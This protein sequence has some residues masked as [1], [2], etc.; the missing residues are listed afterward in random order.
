MGG[1]RVDESMRMANGMKC[2]LQ[3]AQIALGLPPRCAGILTYGDARR[4]MLR[5]RIRMRLRK[6]TK[7]SP[8]LRSQSHFLGDGTF[9]NL[10]RRA[11]CAST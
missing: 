1:H 6:A 2:G 3:I 10:R 5:F 9:G 11:E 4:E 7:V 8:S